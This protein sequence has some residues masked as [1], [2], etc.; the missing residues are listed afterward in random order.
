MGRDK[1]SIR[2][3]DETIAER[4]AHELGK[5]CECVTV[6]GP[7][8]IGGATDHIPDEQDHP[9]PL[10]AI[11][12]IE[13]NRD[14]VF[15]ASCDLPAFRAEI[16]DHL[17]PYLH[18]HEAAV[19]LVDGREQPLCGLYRASTLQSA[20]TLVDAGERR[21]M[22]W[23]EALNVARVNLRESDLERLA[24]NVNTPDDLKSIQP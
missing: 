21:V 1:A 16:F 9:G 3:G 2:I 18:T 19:P 14:A 11:S 17:R 12:R 10:V 15:V 6:L 8:N 5:F 20:R 4:I 7:Q 13:T 22:A 24:A 23:L